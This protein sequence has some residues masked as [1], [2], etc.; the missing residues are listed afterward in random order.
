MTTLKGLITDSFGTVSGSLIITLNN[1][2]ARDD[3]TPK[4][5]FV[6]L[7]K[8]FTITNGVVNLTLEETESTNT[9]YN[10]DFKPLIDGVISENSLDPFPFDAVVPNLAEVD[11]TELVPTGM[12]SDILAT[13]ALRIA[14]IIAK[15]PELASLVG[16]IS[17][18]GDWDASTTYKLGDLVS[19]SP[20]FYICKSL[21]PITGVIPS[22]SSPS[23]MDIT[24]TSDGSIQ[25]GS[26]ISYGVSWD[27]SNLA[28]A[29]KALYPVIQTLAPLA[30]PA[31][32][33][34][35][36]ATTQSTSDNSTRLATTEYVKN[37]LGSY[38][39][40]ASPNLIGTPVA[41]TAS[42]W[43]N[44]TQ[45][46]TTAFTQGLCRPAFYVAKSGAQANNTDNAVITFDTEQLDSDNAFSSNRFTVPTGAG[47]WYLFGALITISYSGGTAGVFGASLRVNGSGDRRIAHMS[48]TSQSC[49][50]CSPIIIQLN[51][52][53]YVELVIR[54]YQSNS[55][56]IG[57]NNANTT[58]FWGVR[59]PI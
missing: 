34:D 15:T 9:S 39:T 29:H 42:N 2:I 30:S 17:P 14:R 38:A 1:S 3:L 44:T 22:A 53:S 45:I 47:G 35:P 7:A 26:D 28:P 32:T 5:L 23:W 31:F 33:G 10:F 55:I 51:A 56:N 21:T 59:L 27:T 48:I 37:N 20:R 11:I 41:P 50:T 8:T 12:V 18:K 13:G 54:N 16:G 25:V 46:A 36:T 57:E 19:Y 4:K 58:Y 24:P 6:P 40:L 49:M 43:T 52:G